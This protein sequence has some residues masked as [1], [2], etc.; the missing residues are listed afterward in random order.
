MMK[1]AQAALLAAA[2]GLA[3]PAP[4]PA[5]SLGPGYLQPS[6]FELV[7][8]T[9]AIVLAKASGVVREDGRVRRFVFDVL[10]VLKGPVVD[11]T[12]TLDGT[13][14]W[15]G[16]SDPAD[17]STCRPGAGTGGCI[18]L[19]YKLD[20][21]FLLF[22]IRDGKTWDVR[23]VPFARVNEEVSGPEA[24]WVEGVRRYLKI[25]ALDGVDARKA[26]L[27]V[28]AA[29][30][31][32]AVPG[33]ASDIDRHFLQ[34]HGS[35]P[36]DDLL[37][38]YQQ[39]P[40]ESGREQVLWAFAH[41]K[42]PQAARLFRDLV[43]SGQWLRVTGPVAEYVGDLKDPLLTSSLLKGLL[44][45][46]SGLRSQQRWEVL[47]AVSRAG[48]A[49]HAPLLLE[50]LK[51]GSDEEAKPLR[52]YFLRHPNP[53]AV[54]ELRRRIQGE[55]AKNWEL[56]LEAAALDDPELV[57]WALA[58]SKMPGEDRWVSLYVLAISPRPEADKAAGEILKG[59][60]PDAISSLIQGYGHSRSP[61]R[62]ERILEGY[63]RGSQFPK[64]R[65]WA[66]QALDSL[67]YE[68]EKD[69]EEASRKLPPEPPAN[70]R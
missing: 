3:F 54:A 9:E 5:C 30:K 20:S 31:E 1:H 65:Q 62:I 49:S 60:D 53:Q 51:S 23:M 19:D 8:D 55:P 68:G 48:D 15:R 12:L 35:K 26:A 58:A 70:D 28:T 21:Q 46:K 13:D 36:F 38:L 67:A 61:T 57:T 40:D 34:P 52:E 2:L 69:A 27:R 7:R 24:P 14:A 10:Q 45:P 37:R 63:A 33:L 59:S 29:E 11:K 41:G 42:H 43:E 25:S 32:K 4:M 50:L 44:D 47:G 18:A 56:T 22:L 66:R 17:F 64:L 39:A 16:A 6:N